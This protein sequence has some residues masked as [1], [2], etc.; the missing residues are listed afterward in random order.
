MCFLGH[1]A[2][3]VFAGGQVDNQP[4]GAGGISLVA[5]IRLDNRM[6]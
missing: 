5:D 4:L 6:S 2:I 3:P 1:R